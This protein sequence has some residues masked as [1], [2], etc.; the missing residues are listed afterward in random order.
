MQFISHRPW[1]YYRGLPPHQ[2]MPM[3][4]VHQAIKSDARTSVRH[5]IEDT[6]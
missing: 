3:L 4:G 5:G 6:R 1:F 2:F